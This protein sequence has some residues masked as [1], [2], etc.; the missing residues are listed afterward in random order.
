MPKLLKSA[1]TQY[2]LYLSPSGREMDRARRLTQEMLDELCKISLLTQ[3]GALDLIAVRSGVNRD[4]LYIQ[5]MSI[6]TLRLV[7]RAARDLRNEY[8]RAGSG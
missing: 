8:V 5:L 4:R 2:E 6:E 3:R 1:L 7:Y